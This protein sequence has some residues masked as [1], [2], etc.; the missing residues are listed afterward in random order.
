MTSPFLQVFF[1]VPPVP[2]E[3]P[4]PEEPP[5]EEPP[6]EEPPPDEPPPPS[7]AAK[8]IPRLPR[9]KQAAKVREEIFAMGVLLQGTEILAPY[10][11]Y[12]AGITKFLVNA[13]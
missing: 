9:K 11:Y 5:P 3:E 13:R 12:A 8:A 6:P 10:G 7:P 1:T 4:P 2:P